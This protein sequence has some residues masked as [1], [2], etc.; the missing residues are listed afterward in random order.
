MASIQVSKAQSRLT[1]VEVV[2]LCVTNDDKAT[3]EVSE[4]CVAV[5]IPVSSSPSDLDI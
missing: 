1:Q 3:N 5:S 2:V 4:S